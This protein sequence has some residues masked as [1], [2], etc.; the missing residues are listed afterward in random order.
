MSRYLVSWSHASTD[1]FLPMQFDYLVHPS[2]SS[3]GAHYCT[4]I[5]EAHSRQS[6]W[7][8]VAQSFPNAIKHLVEPAGESH[9]RC[10]DMTKRMQGVRIIPAKNRR[11]EHHPGY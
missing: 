5:V 7:D 2:V 3:N 1:A 8:Q 9:D 4:S 6:A 11:D 10:F